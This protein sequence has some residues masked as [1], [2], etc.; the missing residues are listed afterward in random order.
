MGRNPSCF[1]KSGEGKDEIGDADTSQFPVE[2]VSWEEAQEFCRKLSSLPEEEALGRVYRLPTEAQWEYACRAGSTT[3]HCF[4][5]D[6]SRLGEYAWYTATQAEG[7]I[8]WARRSPTPGGYT[9]CTGTCGSGV[10]TGM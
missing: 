4:G 10:R 8:R 9:T 2:M 1:C 7:R 6:E 5:D 3:R